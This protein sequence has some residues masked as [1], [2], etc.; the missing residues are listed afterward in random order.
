MMLPSLYL[1]GIGAIVILS[2]LGV[3]IKKIY[4]FGYER[5]DSKMRI[6]VAERDRTIAEQKILIA[7]L[8][9]QEVVIEKEI[10]TVYRDRVRTVTKV[11]KEIVE[12]I[13]D[14]LGPEI[15]R[16]TIGPGFIGLHNAA[17][18]GD[19]TNA[20]SAKDKAISNATTRVDGATD[21]TNSPQP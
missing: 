16:C 14:V 19:S 3:G 15:E 9:L 2:A 21:A 10:V 20:R 18:E 8:E 6:I 11:E 7:E 13:R 5:A 1:K 12:V 17:A 4:D